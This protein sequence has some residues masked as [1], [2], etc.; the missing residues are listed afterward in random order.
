MGNLSTALEKE[1]F[2]SIVFDIR[3]FSW[4]CVTARFVCG[5]DLDVVNQPCT[6]ENRGSERAGLAPDWPVEGL[7]SVRID[8]SDI[9]DRIK[10]GRPQLETCSLPMIPRHLTTLL[11]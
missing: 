6:A 7:E 5:R 1:I 4:I 10:P 8:N 11:F 2:S 9:V 3:V